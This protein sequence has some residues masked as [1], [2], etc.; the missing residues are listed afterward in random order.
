MVR[1]RLAYRRDPEPCPRRC[2]IVG[3]AD[4]DVFLRRDKN[5]RRFVPIL[6]TGGKVYKVIRYMEGYRDR[7]WA[8]A[9]ELY[10]KGVPPRLPDELKLVAHQ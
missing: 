6:L 10:G 8:E 3:T 9:I 1:V 2:V 5:P 7:L 4:R